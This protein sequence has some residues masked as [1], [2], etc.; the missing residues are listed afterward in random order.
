M[1]A[2]LPAPDNS[3]YN[4]ILEDATV[5]D[6]RDTGMVIPLDISNTFTEDTR[7]IDDSRRL[8]DETDTMR[9]GHSLRYDEEV[10]SNATS[11]GGSRNYYISDPICLGQLCGN[12]Y[13]DLE[14][15]IRTAL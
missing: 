1:H 8:M 2:N 6:H 12:G 13:D 9:I 14:Q 3:L 15:E 10:E 7:N 11:I 4:G 5:Y